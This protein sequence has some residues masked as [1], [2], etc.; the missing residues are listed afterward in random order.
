MSSRC[1]TSRVGAGRE[2]DT[3][4]AR[5]PR[6]S[7]APVDPCIGFHFTT[8]HAARCTARHAVASCAV[9]AAVTGWWPPRPE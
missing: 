3:A 7:S 9:P 5:R 8:A 1:A 6:R 2:A 4:V